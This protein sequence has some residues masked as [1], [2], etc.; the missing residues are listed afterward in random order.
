[1]R[2]GQRYRP[3]MSGLPFFSDVSGEDIEVGEETDK[4]VRALG[5]DGPTDRAGL[6]RR[7]RSRFWGPGRFRQALRRGLEEGRIQRSDS[8]DFTVP[9]EELERLG[10]GGR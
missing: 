5:E 7:V 9:D 6:S 3:A 1:M 8:G 4:L 2:P 10:L